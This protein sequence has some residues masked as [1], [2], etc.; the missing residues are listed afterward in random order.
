MSNLWHLLALVFLSDK[1]ITIIKKTII[2][3]HPNTIGIY[4]AQVFLNIN[5]IPLLIVLAK[6]MIIKTFW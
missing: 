4:E 5:K 3:A 6:R 2:E 1:K